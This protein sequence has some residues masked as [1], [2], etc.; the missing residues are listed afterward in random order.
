VVA[1]EADAAVRAQHL[2]AI[3]AETTQAGCTNTLR[4]VIVSAVPDRSITCVPEWVST[5]IA[6]PPL[7]VKGTALAVP[8]SSIERVANDSPREKAFKSG[9]S[10]QSPSPQP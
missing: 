5:S 9:P 3:G 10:A 4:S 7:S 8:A 2:R 6:P 1:A